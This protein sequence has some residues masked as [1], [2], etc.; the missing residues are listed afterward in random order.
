MKVHVLRSV[1]LVHR[2]IRAYRQAGRQT[3]RQAD[4]QAGRRG[5]GKVVHET[6][7]QAGT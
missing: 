3:G 6:G 2:M 4:R 7:R 1:S 5:G